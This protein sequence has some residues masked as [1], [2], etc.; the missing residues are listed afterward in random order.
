MELTV[1]V[2]VMGAWALGS[3]PQEMKREEGRRRRGMWGWSLRKREGVRMDIFSPWTLF[4]WGKRSENGY[5][6][7]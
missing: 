7:C 4:S 3:I 2:C 5:F 1:R 6:H